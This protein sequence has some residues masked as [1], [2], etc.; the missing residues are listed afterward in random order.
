M[1]DIA[2]QLVNGLTM[3]SLY[4]LIALGY[5]MVYGVLRLINFAHGEVFMVGAFTGAYVAR[6]L[7]PEAGQQQTIGTALLGVLAAMAICGALGYLIER[8]AYRPLRNASRLSALITAIGVSLLLQNLASIKWN[9]GG[10]S[11]FGVTPTHYLPLQGASRPIGWISS[12]LG[13][14]IVWMDVILLAVT[15]AV[16]AALYVI[17]MRT[18][19]GQAMRAV[20]MNYDAA[21]LMGINL[22]TIISFT[23]VLGSMLAAVGG[24]LYGLKFP[25]ATPTMGVLVGLKAFVAAVVGGIGNIPGAAAGGLLLGLVEMAVSAMGGSS[26]QNAVAFVILIVVLLV[27]PEGIFG[28]AVPEKV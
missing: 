14:Q 10:Q 15:A 26:Y 4:A 24:C 3:G 21:R 23:F 8:F 2:Q 18:R 9:I 11:Y 1:V 5:T 27:R 6:A 7:H 16:L 13:V 12:T 20:S 19:T 22:N 17:V 28:K 25:T